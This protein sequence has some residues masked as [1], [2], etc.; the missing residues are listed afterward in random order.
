[1]PAQPFHELM[2]A[3]LKQFHLPTEQVS[4]SQEIYT[5]H[6][7][8]QPD[9]H[10]ISKIGSRYIDVM[11]EAARLDNLKAAEPL[12]AVHAL[13]GCGL[14]DPPVMLTV[15]PDSGHVIAWGRQSRQHLN[16]EELTRLLRQVQS[17]AQKVR[18]VLENPDRK[19]AGKTDTAARLTLLMRQSQK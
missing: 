4:P 18:Q 13:N 11:T 7:D 2:R 12:L 14:T 10:L 3:L 19:P 15:Q 16:L 8:G 1:M 5:L 9:V 6:F 17:Q